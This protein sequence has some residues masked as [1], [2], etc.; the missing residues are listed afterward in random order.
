MKYLSFIFLLKFV[1]TSG[2]GSDTPS[3]DRNN[4]EN[5]KPALIAAMIQPVP[6]IA[7]GI[8]TVMVLLQR[9]IA[10]A[11]VFLKRLE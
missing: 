10:G 2:G 9:T 11:Q 1:V 4:G 3:D 7:Q 8:P 5:K 6:L